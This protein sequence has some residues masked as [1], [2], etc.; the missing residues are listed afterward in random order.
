M[1]RQVKCPY[2]GH[3]FHIQGYEYLARCFDCDSL[4]NP[5]KQSHVP[6]GGEVGR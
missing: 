6:E 1:G 2:C 4:F 3:E 5:R